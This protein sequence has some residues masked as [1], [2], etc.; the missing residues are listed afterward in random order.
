MDLFKP[1]VEASKSFFQVGGFSFQ[2]WLCHVGLAPGRG[3]CH[4]GALP[5]SQ[6][7]VAHVEE[8]CVQSG[9]SGHL[10]S[11]GPCVSEKGWQHLHCP[12]Q[13]AP[14]A[15]WGMQ[16]GWG[17]PDRLILCMVPLEEHIAQACLCEGPC[18]GL[19]ICCKVLS[20]TLRLPCFACRFAC[21]MLCQ[22]EEPSC[23]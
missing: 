22:E 16:A 8:E 13:A 10:S 12:C 23:S 5:V 6:R 18:S 1:R 15:L 17:L 19:L 7:G 11:G 20:R 4:A 3:L 21:G 2:E 14:C 9:H